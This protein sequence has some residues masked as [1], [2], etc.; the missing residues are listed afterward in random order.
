[1]KKKEQHNNS[2]HSNKKNPLT[3]NQIE[4]YRDTLIQLKMQIMKNVDSLENDNLNSNK[5]SS[6]DLSSYSLH[7]A[8]MGTDTYDKELAMNVAGNEQDILYQI[9]Q[10]LDRINK[11]TYGICEMHQD[12]IPTS[13]L[14][15]IP[16]TSYCKEAQEKIEK[17]GRKG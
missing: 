1:M 10:A 2:N 15:A 7:M 9:D 8:D 5:E 14:N 11:G 4:H 17:D 6:G 16:W 12:F 13:R 3:K